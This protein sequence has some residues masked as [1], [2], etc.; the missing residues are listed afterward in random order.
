VVG[1][2]LAALV[3]AGSGALVGAMATDAWQATRAGVVHLFGRGGTVRRKVIE[4]QLDGHADLVAR[5]ESPAAV[6]QSLVG[7]WRQELEAL[8]HCCPEAEQELRALMMHISEALPD[9]EQAWTQTNTA[10]D[11][12]TQN[13]VQHGTLNVHSQ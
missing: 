7:L 12:A 4:A 3:E 8:L 1:E 13:I 9:R 6:R 2:A 5:A 10:H 11:H